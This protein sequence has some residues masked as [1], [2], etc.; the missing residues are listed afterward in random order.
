MAI[1]L[2]GYVFK[3]DGT[4]VSGATVQ[5]YDT[6]DDS[7]EGSAVTTNSAGLWTYEDISTDGLY[8]IKMLVYIP[9][10]IKQKNIIIKKII[11][12]N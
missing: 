9:Y 12:I 3:D 5:A 4:A 8:D 7:T 6:A 1:K 2:Q 10:Y 11:F